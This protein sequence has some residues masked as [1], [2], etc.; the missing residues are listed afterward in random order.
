M[1]LLDYV[2]MKDFVFVRDRPAIDHL[3]YSDYKERKTRYDDEKSQCPFAV[4][5]NPFIKRKRTFAYNRS[6]F[7]YSSLF[8][9]E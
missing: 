9:P 7:S 3:V 8:D 4:A 2:E 1:N 5:K 6:N